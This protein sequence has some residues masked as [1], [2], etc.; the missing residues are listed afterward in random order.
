MEV[1]ILGIA[2]EL[3]LQASSAAK[4]DL[5]HIRDL[6]HSLW[7]HWIFNQLSE[8]RDST[9][10]LIVPQPYAGFFTC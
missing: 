8:A 10:I 5:S 1:P 2:S 3:Q 4:P 6:H 9:L 7:Q